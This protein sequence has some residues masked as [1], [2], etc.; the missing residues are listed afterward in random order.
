MR[1]TTRSFPKNIPET[2]ATGR[3]PLE[4]ELV[5]GL[6]LYIRLL[7]PCGHHSLMTQGG[8]ERSND[9]R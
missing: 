9:R 8:G 5:R 7:Y 6:I 3:L 2:Q 4:V 1:K